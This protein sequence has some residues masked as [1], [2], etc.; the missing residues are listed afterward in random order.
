MA[1]SELV[2]LEDVCLEISGLE[3]FIGLVFNFMMQ[4]LGSDWS[5]YMCV[6]AH[7]LPIGTLIDNFG[8][9]VILE[10]CIGYGCSASRC[11]EV[12]EEVVGVQLEDC[13]MDVEQSTEDLET[14]IWFET[15]SLEDDR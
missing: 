3:E 6:V 4:V 13:G 12:A 11:V 8:D 15:S 7:K 1:F 10:R 14:D 2:F 9:P 5:P